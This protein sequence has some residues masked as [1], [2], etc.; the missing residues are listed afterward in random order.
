MIRPQTQQ[1]VRTHVFKVLYTTNT[2]CGENSETASWV[3]VSL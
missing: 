3:Q 1:K 2:I